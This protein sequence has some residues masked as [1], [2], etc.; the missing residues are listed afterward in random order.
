MSSLKRVLAVYPPEVGYARQVLRGISLYSQTRP[1]WV[2]IPCP[3]RVED[4]RLAMTE[5]PDAVIGHLSH[6]RILEPIDRLG[7]PVVNT[8][9]VLADLS[10]P[11]LGVDDFAIGAMGARYLLSRGFRRFAAYLLHDTNFAWDRLGGFRKVIEEAGFAVH[12]QPPVRRE[13]QQGLSDRQSPCH[14]TE[15]WLSSLPRPAAI[16][17]MTDNW[18]LT[19]LRACR[20]IG[21]RVPDDFAVLGVD[22]D[23]MSELTTPPLSSVQPPCRTIG[24]RAAQLLHAI[25]QGQSVPTE[26]IRIPPVRVVTRQSTD[27]EAIA[28]E[29][30]AEAIRFIRKNAARNISVA[31]VAEAA[32][33]PRRTLEVRFKKVLG[34]TPLTGI[35]QVQIERAKGLLADT[36]LATEEIARGVGFR[37]ARRLATVFR[38]L[39][40]QTPSEFRRQ[41]R[42]G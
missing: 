25:L 2:L 34:C 1:D 26:D 5:K 7:K 28:D 41:F 39:A 10:Y 9:N 35:H 40:G 29:Q 6:R 24:Y 16:L 13:P 42:I 17:S 33:L 15:Q 27:I 22:N 8:S 11:R 32:T 14:E 20:A 30:L 31:D 12:V 4:V 23:D 21:A 19:L 36:D 3:S 38:K 37:G 18:A